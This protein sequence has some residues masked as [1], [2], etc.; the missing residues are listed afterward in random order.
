MYVVPSFWKYLGLVSAVPSM[1]GPIILLFGLRSNE[2]LEIE[3]VGEEGLDFVLALSLP[4]FWAYR[5]AA[6]KR[7]CISARL[8]FRP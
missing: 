2:C 3:K 8:G 1:G 5:Q 7:C 4:P 6:V